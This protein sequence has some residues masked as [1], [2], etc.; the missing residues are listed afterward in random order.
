MADGFIWYE[1][2]TTDPD[3]A[4]AFYNE[5]VGWDIDAQ[6]AGEMDYRMIVR[7]DGGHAGG[8][9]RLTGAMVEGGAR[10]GWLGYLNT[11]NVDAVVAATLAEGGS[12]QMPAMDMHVGRMAMIAD[13]QGAVLYVM[14]PVPPE[15]QPDAES[16]VF[17]V[18]QP[19]HV[20][21]NELQSTDPEA[22][23]AFY[24]K[25]F[26][27]TQQG[28]MPMGDLGDYLFIQKDGTGIGA[29]M[30]KLPHVPASGWSFYIGVDDIDRAVAAVEAG[31]GKLLGPVQQIPGGEFT[32]HAMDPQGAAFGLVG[33]R[34]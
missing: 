5:V 19:Q 4:R 3:G 25:H 27:W 33:P 20:R 17:S 24:S 8:V 31:G 32:V 2:M 12:V 11:A 10:A 21:W 14:T 22:S 13:P 16:D 15:G 28:A 6:P 9:M 26:G 1:L 23:V 30:R 29:I 7:S 18:D 34:A